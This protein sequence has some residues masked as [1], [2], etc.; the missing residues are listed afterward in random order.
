[1]WLRFTATGSQV[2]KRVVEGVRQQRTAV[3]KEAKERVDSVVEEHNKKVKSLHDD[4]RAKLASLKFERS[5][6]QVCAKCEGLGQMSGGIA[7]CFEC[8]MSRARHV[9]I[10]LPHLSLG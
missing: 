2:L 3:D 4:H 10:S 5:K 7:S 6:L 9:V 1:M 8:L